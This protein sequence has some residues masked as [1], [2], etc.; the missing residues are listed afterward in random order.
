M[1]FDDR[2]LNKQKK[3]NRKKENHLQQQ[4]PSFSP[5]ASHCL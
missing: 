3:K 1:N 4:F 5:V 2:E